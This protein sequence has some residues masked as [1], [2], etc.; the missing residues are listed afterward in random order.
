MPI[1]NEGDPAPAFS[2]LAHTGETITLAALRGTSVLLWFYPVADT[3][4]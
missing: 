3:P 2:C 1:L 4:G